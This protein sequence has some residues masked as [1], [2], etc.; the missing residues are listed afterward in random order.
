MPFLAPVFTAVAT[1]AASS[2]AAGFLVQLGTSLLL[3]AA[4]RAL[5]PT[6]DNSIKGRTVTVR[7]PVAPRDIV[8][9][10]VRKGGVTIFMNTS[11]DSGRYL[12]LVI[13]LAGHRVESIGAIYFNGEEAIAAGEA[14]G[15]GKYASRARV[16]RALGA[17]DQLA[18]PELRAALP[19]LWTSNHRLRGVAAIHLRLTF[20]N[21][22]FP[23][24][25]PNI[26]VDIEGKNDILDPRLGTRGYSE[27]AALCVA[28]FASL[29][30][31]G[32]GAQI[33]AEDGIDQASVIAAANICDEIVAKVAGGTEPRYTCNGVV[34]LAEQP[35]ATIEAMLTAMAG[36]FIWQAGQW[37]LQAGAYEIP[38]TVLTGDD[39]R[40]RG[41]SMSTRVS[42]AS[43]FNAVRGTFVSPENDWQPDDFPAYASSVY[44]AEDGGER[45]YADITLPFTTSADTAQRLAKITLERQR[46]QLSVKVG[47]KFK[48]W[49][50]S[51][52][53]TVM[54]TYP[55]WGMDEKPFYVQDVSLDLATA[56]GG[57]ALL[58]DLVLQ[59]TSPL[60]Y[61]AE[62]SEFEIYAAAPRTTLPSAFGTEPPAP[63]TAIEQLYETRGGG[64][65]KVRALVSTMSD[66]PFVA[67]FQF[68]HR[69]SSELPEDAVIGG[70]TQS[71]FT[72]IED[73]LPGTYI[74]GVRTTTRL[75]VVSDWV[76]SNPSP[77]NG[78]NAAPVAIS[79]LSVQAAGGA[80][81]MLR[82]QRHPSLDV[83]QGGR[84]EF[85]HSAAF[86][87]ATW[88]TS[89]S[90][91]IAVNGGTT[92]A[93]LPLKPG[94]YLARAYDAQ[95]I[96]GPVATIV[97]RAANILPTVTVASIT[98]SP[99]FA[100]TPTGCTVSGGTLTI[101]PGELV[102]T[103]DFDE[104]IDLTTVQT[105][106]LITLV[107][108]LVSGASDLFWQPDAE[109]FW[110][111]P[112]DRFWTTSGAFGDVDVQVQ[113]TD[114]DPSGTPVWSEWQSVD[115][116]DFEARAFRLRAL[117]SV[118]DTD[119]SISVLTLGVTAIQAM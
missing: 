9:G 116:A 101:N 31:F 85:R 113:F 82:W 111:V 81:A 29:D 109:S 103:Y 80:V 37:R 58:P 112:G 33:G 106:R 78:I 30:P 2:A 87:G 28:D 34:S 114:D 67:T 60:V 59:E 27:N 63:P 43:N 40:E 5:T 11:G 3:T 92:E 19:S 108:V 102:A 89:T 117:L 94:T 68:S 45:R 88:Q 20:N 32:I 52:G 99:T 97:T 55:R 13:V 56:N 6:P 47:G 105:V 73:L 93:A 79:G 24:G 118:E 66:N 17:A 96:R 115:A 21:E 35:K 46:R 84:I 49:R 65:I 8:Y 61:D 86:E 44:L 75:G 22:A 54:L 74:F 26:T 1:F 119:F 41:F 48:A 100:G 51:T 7:E 90:I 36:K 15:S 62:A 77:I 64:G 95:G 83:R 71:P 39:A 4:A 14:D 53:E 57:G 104:T 69:L 50:V 72:L 91:G 107:S 42:M 23:S 12:D 76:F 18:F 98:E 110:D 25:I 70:Q 16:E 10:N 38:T